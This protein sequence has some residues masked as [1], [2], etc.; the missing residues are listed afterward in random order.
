[1]KDI[2]LILRPGEGGH[3]MYGRCCG[4]DYD[5]FRDLNDD[6]FAILNPSIQSYS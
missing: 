3:E 4:S 1:M 5:S 6:S 2:V